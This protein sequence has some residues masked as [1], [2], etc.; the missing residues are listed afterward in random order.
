M[1]RRLLPFLLLLGAFLSPACS[2]KSVA[3]PGAFQPARSDAITKTDE[4]WQ[5]ELSQEQYRILRQAGTERPFTGKNWNTV[6]PGTYHCG[7][8]GLD[9]F[10]SEH[11][12]KSGTGWPSFTQPISD[13]HVGELNDSTLGMKRTEVLCDRCGG[14]LGHVFEDGPQPT[15]LRYCINGDAMDFIPASKPP[16]KADKPAEPTEEK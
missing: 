14:H 15:G 4:E 10:H 7:A 12:F 6:E 13:D 2:S 11:K 8:C 1:A 5:A 9:L 16:L 3:E